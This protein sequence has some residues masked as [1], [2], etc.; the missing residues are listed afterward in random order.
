MVHFLHP[1]LWPRGLVLPNAQEDPLG[2][3]MVQEEASPHSL[4]A[5]CLDVL[6]AHLEKWCSER[7]DGTLCL[8]EY[9]CFPQ[10]IAD[11]FLERLAWQGKLTDRTAGIFQGKQMSLKRLKIQKAKLSAA[12]FTRAFCHHKLVDVDA[13][14]VDPELPAPDIIHG[15]GSNAWIRENLQCLVLDSAS[16]PENSRLPT[17]GQFTGVHT[18]SVANVSFWSEDLVSVSQL[19]NL[20]SLDIS[21]THVTDISALLTCKNRLRSFTMHYLKCLAMSN[22]QILAVIRQLNRLRHLDISDHG[23]LRSNLAFHL[24]QQEEILPELVSLDI[25]G[26]TDVTDAAVESFLR[27][28]PEMRFVGLLSTDAGYSDFFM[29]KQG[30]KVAGGAN[31]SQISESLSRY[32]SRSC[33]LKEA[34]YRLFTETLSLHTIMPTVLKLVVIGMRNHP[35]DLPVQFTASACILNLIHQDLARGMPVR[36]LSEA[37]CLLLKAMKNFPYYQQLQ[38]NCLLFLTSSRILVDVPFDRFDVAKLVL[39]WLCRRENPKM[40]TM[41]VSITSVLALK[42][43]P[44]EKDQLQEELILAVK[45]L[46]AIA[47]QKTTENLNDVTFLFTLNALWNLT[48]EC[49]SACKYFIANDGLSVIIQ[50]LETFSES[51]IQNKVLGLLNNVAEVR[52]LA[53]ALMTEDLMGHIVSL[54]HSE[55]IEVSFFAAGVVAHLTCDRQHWLSRDRQRNDLLQDLHLT[56]QNWPSSQCK[57][58][59]LVTYRSFKPLYLLLGNFSQPEVQLW[60]LWAMHHVCSKNPSKY[61]KLLVE[62]GGLQLIC[63]I[64]EH[65]QTSAQVRQMAASILGDFRMHFTG[66]QRPPQLQGPF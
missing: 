64:Q 65:G 24:L 40:Q 32:R 20:E 66:Y 17:L 55:N 62:E 7:P 6:I 23:Q 11:K 14:S 9:W 10:E 33:F 3:C 41:A 35:L 13:A 38:K 60:A 1:M 61:C 59:A 34:L 39:G 19:P 27:Q 43:S 47:R 44:K 49:P 8:P 12:A 56:M 26:G 22:S 4:F 54:L 15:L 58:S 21:N 52:E 18:L 5:I 2:H 29:T 42:L 63:D 36:L 46:L 45:E 50:V 25:S 53:S 31:M 57:M 28:R 51:V 48:D 37:I 30:L 16:A